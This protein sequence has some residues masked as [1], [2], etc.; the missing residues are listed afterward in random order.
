METGLLSIIPM[1]HAEADAAVAGDLI[2]SRAW[3]KGYESQ[4]N[5]FYD[6]ADGN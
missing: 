6:E 1:R 2:V 3:R 5:G 4:K